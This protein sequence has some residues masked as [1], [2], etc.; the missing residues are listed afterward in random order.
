MN[1]LVEICIYAT[2]MFLFTGINGQDM[3]VVSVDIDTIKPAKLTKEQLPVVLQLMIEYEEECYNDSIIFIKNQGI[4]YQ[5]L[6]NKY[7]KY[8][9]MGVASFQYWYFDNRKVDLL[10]NTYVY[11][12]RQPDIKDFVLWVMEKYEL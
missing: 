6:Q 9:P 12:H 2:F 11:L 5:E 8:L 1:K 4:S 3:F 7:D 10:G